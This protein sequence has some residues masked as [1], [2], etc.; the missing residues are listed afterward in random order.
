MYYKYRENIF[1]DFLVILKRM[2]QNLEEV[3]PRYCVD[4][5]V[6]N[7]IECPYFE[8]VDEVSF[9]HSCRLHSFIH[10]VFIDENICCIVSRGPVPSA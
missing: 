6:S 2:L 5:D 3:F 10:V 1:Q 9:F 8:F 7:I 4:S